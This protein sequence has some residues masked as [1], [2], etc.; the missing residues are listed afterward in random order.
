[1]VVEDT[2]HLVH[3]LFIGGHVDSLVEAPDHEG[4]GNGGVEADGYFLHGE[5]C[6]TFL[7]YKGCGRA[8]STEKGKIIF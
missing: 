4:D 6:G 5:S 3:R 2:L 7:V 1:V 8:V